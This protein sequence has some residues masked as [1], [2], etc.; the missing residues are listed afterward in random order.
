MQE[1]VDSRE[2]RR[3]RDLV[4]E[5]RDKGYDVVRRPEPAA[6]PA[7]LAGFEIDLLARSPTDN[8]LVEIRSQQTLAGA[9]D[10]AQMAEAVSCL[11]GWRLEL[12]V[13]N[14]REKRLPENGTEPL[15]RAEIR[16]RLARVSELVHGDRLDAA[17]LLAWSAAEGALRR[18]ALEEA[19]AFE[20]PSPLPL[21]K[22]LYS[23]GIVSR[24]D[25]DT[26][27]EDLPL[28]NMLAHGYRSGRI[29]AD[30]IRRLVHVVGSLVGT[31]SEEQVGG[32]AMRR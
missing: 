23:L 5:Y 14:P 7:C 24:A 25:Y 15:T 21:V 31:G 6:L 4:R 2:K 19:I 12:V 9:T 1:T 16:D 27:V 22:Q 30:V 29:D 32:N 11:P 26:I 3:L 10:L 8:V 28:Q 13:T 20:D 18:M 17:A